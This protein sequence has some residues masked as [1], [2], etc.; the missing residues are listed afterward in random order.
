MNRTQLVSNVLLKPPEHHGNHLDYLCQVTPLK[1]QGKTCALPSTV[2]SHLLQIAS[3]QCTYP[4]ASGP[5]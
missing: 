4:G 2:E 1:T 3:P 5:T